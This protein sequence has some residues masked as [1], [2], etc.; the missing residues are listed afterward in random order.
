MPYHKCSKIR[1]LAIDYYLNNTSTTYAQTTQIFQ[2]SEKTFKRWLKQYKEDGS[3]TRKIILLNKN[4]QKYNENDEII[5]NDINNNIKIIN[6]AIEYYLRNKVTQQK[7]CQIFKIET[8]T[9]KYL[10]KK[11]KNLQRIPNKQA[12]TNT[13]VNSPQYLNTKKKTKINNKVINKKTNIRKRFVWN[14]FGSVYQEMNKNENMKNM[15]IYNKLFLD[16]KRFIWQRTIPSKRITG[17]T[18]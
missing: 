11:Y 15:K 5:Y 9:F 7:V 1:K 16:S 17:F 13:N 18:F 3:L 4:K 12:N 10:L 8:K 6:F 2:I 14:N